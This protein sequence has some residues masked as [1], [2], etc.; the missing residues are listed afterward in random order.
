MSSSSRF[1]RPKKPRKARTLTHEKLEEW[2]G[3][4]G[5]PMPGVSMIDGYLA[6]LVVSPQFIPPEEWLRPIVGEGIAWAPD[7]SMEEVVR[8][9]IFQRYSQ[10][11]ATLS[12]GPKRYAPIYMRT[13]DGEVLLEQFANGFYLGMRRSIDDW[14]PHIS[15]PEIGRPLTA[16]LGHCTTM[17]PEDQRQRALQGQATE[18]LAQSWQVVPEL[19]EMLHVRLAG[20]RNVEIR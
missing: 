3:S 12:G 18:V 5:N 10:I 15:N 19:I 6:A 4:R 17:M 14:K 2:L 8:N 1:K 9:T 7:G 11:G 20:A 16:I 13:D